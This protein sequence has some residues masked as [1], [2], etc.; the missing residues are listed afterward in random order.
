MTETIRIAV[1][2]FPPFETAIVRQFEDFVR[3]SGVDA[4]VEIEAFDLNPLHERLF[5]RQALAKGE[6]D[7]AFLSTDWIA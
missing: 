5:E 4:R 2:K 1:R 6:F 3:A 7:I